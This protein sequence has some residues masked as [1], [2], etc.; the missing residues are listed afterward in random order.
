MKPLSHILTSVV[1]VLAIAV[2]SPI[3]SGGVAA[4]TEPQGHESKLEREIDALPSAQRADLERKIAD[5]LET[6]GIDLKDPQVEARL[7]QL[8]GV[9][10]GEIDRAVGDSEGRKAGTVTASPAA[11][12]LLIFLATALIFAPSAFRS[13][14]GT[15]YEY[16]I[17]GG[18][19][20]IEALR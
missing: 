12:V 10:K 15:L 7:A 20:G 9:G 18:V 4:A 5:G 14:G 17:A 13:I 19:E 3:G 1:L 11:G 16:F 8:L 2:A 6:A